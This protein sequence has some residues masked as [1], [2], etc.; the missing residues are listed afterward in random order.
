[1]NDPF[2]L[3]FVVI[4][5]RKCATSWL[6]E[7]FLRHPDVCVSPLVKQ[8][9]YF[10]RNYHKGL[11]WYASLYESKTPGQL[12]GEVDPDLISVPEAP[13]RIA[14]LAPDAKIIAIFRNP[15]DQFFSSYD[16]ARGKGMVST[17]PDETWQ[18]DPTFRH[19]LSYAAMLQRIYASFPKERVLVLFFEE[20]D[21]DPL[22]VLGTISR[23]LGIRNEYEPSLIGTR[24]NAAWN[25]RSSVMS[26]ILTGGARLARRL[27]LHNLVNWVKALP[28]L[29]RNFQIKDR[30]E[31][32]AERQGELRRRILTEMAPEIREFGRLANVDVAAIWPETRT[33]LSR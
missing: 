24:V 9:N 25:S 31:V 15:P 21:R 8:S 33:V 19:D 6:Y 30:R 28:M 2:K 1:M 26:R 3:D 4:G 11:E 29:R 10:G 32:E 18:E 16:H 5:S 20:I 23:F 14:Q 22:R 7:L 17:P 13:E 12:V 27:D